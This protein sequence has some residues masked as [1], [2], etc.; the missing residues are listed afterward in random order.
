ML[1]AESEND[2]LTDGC[3]EGPTDGLKLKRN[4]LKRGYNIIPGLQIRGS[5]GNFS[6]DFLEFSI[7]N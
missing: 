3:T 5:K 4:F 6:I 2:A 7:E 1:P